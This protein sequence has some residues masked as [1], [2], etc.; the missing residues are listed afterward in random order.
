LSLGSTNIVSLGGADGF[1]AML[2]QNG[3]VTNAFLLAG[4]ASDD[5]LSVI[6]G[7]TGYDLIAG[8]Q[9]GNFSGLGVQIS[10]A[11]PFVLTS[12]AQTTPP[13]ITSQPQSVTVNAYANA[14]FKVTAS[15][16]T[17]LNYQWSFN[18]TNIS[19]ATASSLTISNLTQQ[20]LGAYAVVVTNAYGTITSSNAMLSM[21]PFLSS[22]FGGVVTDWGYNATLSVQAWGT[23]PLSYQWFDNGVAILNATNQTLTL[24][25]IQFTN[26]GLYSVVVSSP[27]G[28]VTNTPEQVVV[29]PAGVSLGMYP[30]VTVSGTVG[31]TYAIQATADLS[32][33][34]SWTTVATM[35][36]MQPVQLWV[37]INVNASSPTNSHR[38][39]RVMPGD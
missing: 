25:S 15:G 16:T 37:D 22:P 11:G 35:T 18:G 38:F 7:N 5:V 23:G 30:G 36:L 13:S 27:F 21:Y 3:N 31:Y 28:S 4:P 10:N 24:T 33:T 32:N 17:P 2:D 9:G 19:G 14:T 20:A 26:A 39:Y 12:Y 29:N 6:A 8:Q 34:N 1:V